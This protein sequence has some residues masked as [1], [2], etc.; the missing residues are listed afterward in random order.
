MTNTIDCEDVER[1][2]PRNTRTSA[3]TNWYT[4]W[5]APAFSTNYVGF[6]TQQLHSYEYAQLKFMHRYSG[7]AS[8][9]LLVVIC[10]S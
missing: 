6:M 3:G 10:N 5:R 2:E 7:H 1:Q 4:L 9:S 8:E